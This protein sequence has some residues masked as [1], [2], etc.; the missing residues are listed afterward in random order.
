MINQKLKSITRQ[1]LLFNPYSK[2]LDK[3]FDLVSCICYTRTRWEVIMDF[4]ICEIYAWENV[5][6]IA[7]VIYNFAKV[8]Q[9]LIEKGVKNFII[10]T[11]NDC[12]RL[13]LEI[14]K[15]IKCNKRIKIVAEKKKYNPKEICG[16]VILFNYEGVVVTYDKAIMPFILSN[17]FSG[18][19]FVYNPYFDVK[20]FE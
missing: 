15:Q 2:M 7:S 10:R 3:L 9:S 6:D 4:D 14:I 12:T 20:M 17:N 5:G 13:C 19:N 11:D 1:R 16:Y 8:C 18:T